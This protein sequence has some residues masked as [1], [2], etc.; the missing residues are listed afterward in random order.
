MT[1]LTK[2]EIIS[3]LRSMA[4]PRLLYG[5]WPLSAEECAAVHERFIELGLVTAEGD[6]WRITDLGSTVKE[7]LWSMFI[8]AHDL[9]EHPYILQ[10]NG[11]I[12]EAQE[13]ALYDQ[14]EAV[15]GERYP[16]DKWIPILLPIVRRAYLQYQA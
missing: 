4:E 11:F 8:G 13:A 3:E 15:Q 9:T 5:T 2:N 10:S 1:K 12:D 7:G 16:E 14:M 6:G